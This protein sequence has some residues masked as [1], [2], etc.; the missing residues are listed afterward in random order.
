MR[1]TVE[2]K[3]ISLGN[4]SLSEVTA[5]LSEDEFRHN[6][7][8]LRISNLIEFGRM[9]HAEMSALME[10]ARRGLAVQ[11]GILVCTTFPCHMCARH[12][13]SAGIKVVYFIEPYPKSMA[14]EIYNDIIKIDA[15]DDDVNVKGDHVFFQSYFGTA[16]KMFSRVFSMR[17]RKDELGYS[18]DFDEEKAQPVITPLSR[19]HL[20]SELIVS[21]TAKFIPF[22]TDE[23]AVFDDQ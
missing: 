21:Q 9:V 22:V 2:A 16:P 13:I 1:F 12:I 14:P 4:K 10:A 15:C 18:L 7:K 17:K 23:Q 8:H 5:S 3:L 11:D 19:S 6:F 20:S